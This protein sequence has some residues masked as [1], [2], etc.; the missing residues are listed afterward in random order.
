MKQKAG[1]LAVTVAVVVLLGFMVVMYR[2]FFPPMPPA[3]TDNPKGMPAYAQ[4][5]LEQHKQGQQPGNPGAYPGTS[6]APAGSASSSSA[7][8]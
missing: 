3:D 1:P 4:K 5:W 6:S 8:H 7:G 2:Y